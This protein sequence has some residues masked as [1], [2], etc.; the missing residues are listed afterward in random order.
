M[1]GSPAPSANSGTSAISGIAARSWNNN[2]EKASRPC[3]VESSFFSSST[4][5]AKA[6]D[7][8]DRAKPMNSAWLKLSPRAMA[9]AASTTAVA[10]SCAAPRPK[11]AVRIDQSLTGRSSSPITNKS[12]TTPNSP[13]CS[14]S[15]TSV[16]A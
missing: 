5:S 16:S 6:V 14:T 2:T 9:M 11:I 8:S 12:S 7:D 13:K 4:W 15:R 10:V 3:R 1:A